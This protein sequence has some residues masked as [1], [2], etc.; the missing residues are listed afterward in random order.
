MHALG[1]LPVLADPG[2]EFA[3]L[4]PQTSHSILCFARIGEVKALPTSEGS[5][6]RKPVEHSATP[7]T[8]RTAEPGARAAE[9]ACRVFERDQTFDGPCLMAVG[10]PLVA[11]NDGVILHANPNTGDQL[12]VARPV[13]R[14]GSALA[15][16]ACSCQASNVER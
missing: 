7:C 14:E 12:S 6:S 15:Q 2:L 4:S 11:E 3:L 8:V 10:R 1:P 9:V 5:K 13:P 16:K